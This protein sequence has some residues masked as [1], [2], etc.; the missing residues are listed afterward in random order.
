[1][2]HCQGDRVK[3]Y[4][5]SNYQSVLL[6]VFLS[7]FAVGCEENKSAQ[8]AHI[9]QISQDVK[10]SNQDFIH[11]RQQS[12]EIKSWLKAA[13]NFEQAA[14][15]LLVLEL[16]QGELITYQNQLATIYRIY[17]Q[18]TYDAVRARENQNLSALKSAR[19]DAV[20]AGKIQH[21]LIRQIN[22]YCLKD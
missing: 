9:L 12:G 14:D 19:E 17:S 15:R 11:P 6:F 8:C 21:Q 7:L 10:K 13:N 4:F 2:L 18:A 3:V 16:N 20:K 5:R 22:T 1:M